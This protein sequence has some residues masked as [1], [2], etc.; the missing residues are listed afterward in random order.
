M[1]VL[2]TF[3]SLLADPRRRFGAVLMIVVLILGIVTMHAMS[4]SSDSHAFPSSPMT[5]ISSDGTS[6]GSVDQAAGPAPGTAVDGADH[7]GDA[8]QAC[9]HGCGGHELVTAMCL[10]VLA[11]LLIVVV[12]LR[13]LVFMVGRTRA[14]PSRRAPGSGVAFPRAPSLYALSISRT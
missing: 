4:G 14:G 5:T 7:A 9:D 1:R 3:H 2:R 10:M 11:V 13:R 6:G 8:S 12:P